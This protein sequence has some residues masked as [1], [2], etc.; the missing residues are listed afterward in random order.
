MERLPP[1]FRTRVQGRTGQH[2]RF[3]ASVENSKRSIR[4]R[5]GLQLLSRVGVGL[6][7]LAVVLGQ[8]GGGEC[9]LLVHTDECSAISPTV[10]WDRVRPLA[11]LVRPRT[12][13]EAFR[14][15]AEALGWSAPSS[16]CP[17]RLLKTARIC[18]APRLFV[19]W[20]RPS[21]SRTPVVSFR[22]EVAPVKM[23][24][25]VESSAGADPP[26]RADGPGR[27]RPTRTGHAIRASGRSSGALERCE[28]GFGVARRRARRRAM[29]LTRLKRNV[30]FSMRREHK[31]SPPMGLRR[32]R[33]DVRE[34]A[35]RIGHA[36]T[37]GRL[38]WDDARRR[39]RPRAATGTRTCRARRLDCRSAPCAARC[40]STAMMKPPLRRPIEERSSACA[41][42]GLADVYLLDRA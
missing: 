1:V 13:D 25:L 32:R 27:Q 33:P 24:R 37:R 17:L 6:P 7:R 2:D 21:S 41:Q 31:S 20:R 36:D 42:G 28:P 8:L 35:R 18:Q 5:A 15:H 9:S 39:E 10:T 11:F 34:A 26:Q 19:Q 12:E 14:L 3:F 38:T 30:R 40:G 4:H 23:R 16:T 29:R 22:H